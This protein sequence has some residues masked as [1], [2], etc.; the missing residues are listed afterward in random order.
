LLYLCRASGDSRHLAALKEVF[1]LI[2]SRGLHPEH[3]CGITAFD[4]DWN[5]VPDASGRWTTSYG[6]NAEMSWLLAEAADLLHYPRKSHEEAILSLTD[7]AL[8]CG[9][10]RERG[11]LAAFG[12]LSGHVSGAVELPAARLSKTWWAQ[13]EM[14]N[15]LTHAYEWT[16][17]VKYVEALLKLF[18]WIWKHQV[19]HEYGDWYV[20]VSWDSGQPL[21]LE[22]GLEWKTAFHVS[23]ALI[24]TSQAI[25]RILHS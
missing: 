6:L 23:R 7:H 22:K 1:H 3:R 11:G 24:Q 13:A 17:H 20:E 16:R 4:Y 9:F 14:L 2:V 10:D 15:A 19:D 8:E 18:D 12:P 21:T 25:D 5:P